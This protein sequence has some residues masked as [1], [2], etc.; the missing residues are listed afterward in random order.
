MGK[1]ET[2]AMDAPEGGVWSASRI[3][4]YPIGGG[5]MGAHQDAILSGI[6]D[7][8]GYDYFQLLVVMSEKGKDFEMGGSFIEENG[9]R[10]YFEEHCQLGDIVIYNGA[11]LHGVA[12]VDPH[13]VLNLSSINGRIAGFVSL[14]KDLS[15]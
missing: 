6:A 10:L 5:F 2:F 8:V 9:E 7:E 15:K 3:H 13:K 11:T 12:D 1:H 4:Q 14:Y